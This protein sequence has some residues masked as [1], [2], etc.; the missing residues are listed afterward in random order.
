MNFDEGEVIASLRETLE[1][2]VEKEMPRSAAQ[3]WDARNH[4]PRDVHRKLADIGVLGLTIPEAYG[5]FG[6]DIVATMVVIEE[7]SRRSLAVSVPYIMAACYA[8]MNIEECGTEAQKRELLPRI[9]AG[10]LLF[11]YGLTEPDAGADLASIKT[12]AERDGDILRINGAKRFCSG[13]GI[14]DYV[15]TLVRTGPAEDRHRNLSFVLIPPDAP[16]VTITK[17]ESMGM[18][19]AP[20]T[21]TSF[22]NVEVPIANLVG[23]EA[24]WNKGW[25]MLV[26][27]GLDVEKL[28]VAAIGIGIARAALDDAWAYALERR[29]FGKH[30]ADFQSIQHKLA[31]MKTQIHAARLT[32]YHAAWLANERRPCS[33]ET[34]MAKL[35]ATEVAKAAALECQTIL[36][37]YGYV[38]DFDAE[39]YVRDALLMPIIGGSSAVQRNNIFKLANARR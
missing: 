4:F 24:A 10:D 21:D 14:A 30:I 12:R 5:G 13:A 27:P 1:R 29:Q 33:V 32:L 8:G 39:R 34:S 28:E 22:D 3:D 25:P 6:R 15:Y 18:K 35:F 23:G 16:G 36:G 38:K 11:A 31:D 19:G 2:F 20:T 17:I 37:A 26:G 9:V 7:L